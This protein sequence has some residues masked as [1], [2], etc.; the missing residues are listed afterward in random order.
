MRIKRYAPS[1]FWLLI[2]SGILLNSY[3]GSQPSDSINT[4]NLP[5]PFEDFSLYDYGL[6]RTETDKTEKPP[7]DITKRKFEPVKEIFEKDELHFTDSIKSFWIKFEIVNNQ[8]SDATIALIFP[9]GVAKAVL[10]M[11]GAFRKS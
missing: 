7:A 6:V 10:P 9:Q 2:V 11:E 1:R 5:L 3:A 4:I 8:S